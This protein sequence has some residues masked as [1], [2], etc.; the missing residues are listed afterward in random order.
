MEA[1]IHTGRIRILSL[2]ILPC[3]PEGMNSILISTPMGRGSERGLSFYGTGKQTV[4]SPD[5]EKDDRR[6]EGC[7]EKIFYFSVL[8]KCI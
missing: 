6:M 7:D 8:T 3:G 1:E 4:P 2:G 5:N